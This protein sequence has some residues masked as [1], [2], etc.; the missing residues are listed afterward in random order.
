MSPIP[1]R[2]T[3]AKTCRTSCCC[4]RSC[5]GLLAPKEG[6]GTK[7]TGGEGRK[8]FLGARYT[9]SETWTGQPHFRIES[10]LQ[11]KLDFV[12]ILQQY[13]SRVCTAVEGALNLSKIE[14]GAVT[15]GPGWSC[16]HR[17]GGQGRVL[18]RRTISRPSAKSTAIP[19][20]SKQS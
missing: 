10:H 19:R 15:Q 6:D 11:P 1:S 2:A 14:R 8:E 12:A 9:L 20:S 13:S 17:G 18:G 7:R 16:G 3:P 4:L 5:T